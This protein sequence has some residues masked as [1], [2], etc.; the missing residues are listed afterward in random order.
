MKSINV[1]KNMDEYLQ[2]E[3]GRANNNCYL[4]ESKTRAYLIAWQCYYKEDGN[5]SP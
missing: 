2:D 1:M 5:H 4:V 3:G